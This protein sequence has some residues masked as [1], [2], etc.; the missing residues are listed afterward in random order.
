MKRHG[1]VGGD[2]S[3]GASK[4][5]RKGGS[6]ASGAEY[7]AR[8]FPGTKMPGRMGNDLITVQNLQLLKVRS[9]LNS[10]K[11]YGI[12]LTFQ[13]NTEDQILTIRGHIPGPC[14]AWVEVR[15]AVKTP[16]RLPPP[17]PTHLPELQKNR[18][19]PTKKYLRLQVW[20]AFA[21]KSHFRSVPRSLQ[22]G[23]KCRLG[24]TMGRGQN[25]PQICPAGRWRIVRRRR[26]RRCRRFIDVKNLRRTR[27]NKS[28]NNW[29]V[30]LA[31]TILKSE[32][33]TS[34]RGLIE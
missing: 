5:H 19:L 4:V 9:S 34:N 15:D 23:K 7:P 20:I 1:F 11:F 8:V 27:T 16:H 10:G 13:I 29:P 18:P 22:R 32:F 17:F 26:G 12:R 24:Y 2:A 21:T 14:G 6:I 28:N 30:A 31:I 33:C 25:C 3:H